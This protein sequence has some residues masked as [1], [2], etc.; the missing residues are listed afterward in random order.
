MGLDAGLRLRRIDQNSPPEIRVSG[1][2]GPRRDGF[3][4]GLFH[5]RI[6]VANYKLR[7]HLA[8]DVGQLGNAG[9]AWDQEILE[10][11][12]EV[13]KLAYF[14]H[15]SERGTVCVE[16]WTVVPFVDAAREASTA[17]RFVNDLERVGPGGEG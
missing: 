2:A 10:H 4:D 15:S 13:E 16:H 9:V 1:A 5:V 6:E 3:V 8:Q 17:L 12:Q 7:V 14:R 11:A